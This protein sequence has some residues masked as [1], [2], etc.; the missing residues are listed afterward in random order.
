[1][2]R[3][4]SRFWLGLSGVLGAL[5]VFLGA[6]GAHVLQPLLPLQ[7]MTIFQ[8]AVRY[9]FWHVLALLACGVLMEVFP[10]RVKVLR[11]SA[12]LFATGI[13]L[14]SGSLYGLALTGLNPLGIITPVGGLAWIAAWGL[15]AYAFFRGEGP[16]P[17][18][19]ED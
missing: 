5:G 9:H 15:L 7:V 14:F 4:G 1:M 13:V 16:A 8:S 2:E 17:R 3:L 12:V 10:G 19:H 6:F 11:W 18:R